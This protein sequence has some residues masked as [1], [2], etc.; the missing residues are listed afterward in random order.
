LG[1]GTNAHGPNEMFVIDYLKKFIGS[2]GFVLARS[3]DFKKQKA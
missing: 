2:M 3:F 1:P